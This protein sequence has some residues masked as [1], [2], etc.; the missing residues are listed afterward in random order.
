MTDRKKIVIVYLATLL[1]TSL[2]ISAIFLA[3][4]LRKAE[5]VWG[6]FLYTAFSPVC[7]QIPERCF[8]LWGFPL[9]VCSRCTGIYTGI[10]IGLILFA[11]TNRFSSISVPQTG[12]FILLSIP[13]F[14]DTAGNLLHLWKTSAWMRFAIGSVWGVILPFFFVPGLSEAWIR[15]GEKKLIES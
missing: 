4:L 7:H 8:F 1:A 9:A 10:L 12:L 5:S 15:Q 11:V 13:L 6:S 14:I 2:W 3:P